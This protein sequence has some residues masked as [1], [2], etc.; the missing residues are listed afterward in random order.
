MDRTDYSI[1]LG[2]KNRELALPVVKSLHPLKTY[3][4]E[5]DGYPS[6]SKLVNDCI[7]AC[8][9][10]IIIFC[11]HKVRPT[12]Q[13]IERLLKLIDDGHGLATLYRFG[14]F[15]FKKELIRR[16]G[17]MDERYLIGGW[18]DDDFMIRLKEANISF[19][20]DESIEYI[21]GDSTWQHPKDKPFVSQ[22]HFKTKW[23]RDGKLHKMK[24]MMEEPTMPDKSGLGEAQPNV[25]FK[26]W[27]ESK[28]MSMSVW[29]NDF[30]IVRPEGCIEKKRILIFGGTGS[31]GNKLVE[32]YGSLNEIHVFSRDENKHWNMGMV[33]KDV[34]FIIGDIRNGDRVLEVV[35][36]VSADI[37]IVASAMKHVDRCE[38]EVSEAFETNCLGL[39]NV[40]KA[41]RKTQCVESVVFVSTDKACSPINTYGLT[42]GLGEKVMVAAAYKSLQKPEG[43]T[44]GKSPK[45]VTVRYGNV[46]NSRGSIIEVLNN[47]GQSIVPAYKL[48]HPDMTRF[49]MTQEHAVRLIDYALLHGESGDIIIPKLL[50]MKI[51]DLVEL[52][53]DKYKKSIVETGLRPGEKMHEALLNETELCR[54][55]QKDKYFVIKPPFNCSY[56]QYL[57]NI[58]Y[59]S[60][61]RAPNSMATKEQLEEALQILQLI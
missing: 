60:S 51:K 1:I 2:V 28:I 47:V 38:Y 12:P 49:L 59:D 53:A 22:Q 27:S 58:R 55:I 35:E 56:T 57:P 32:M 37:V 43:T 5:G 15:G 8:P 39:M 30:D 13:D 25:Q 36:S 10:E 18:E 33:H 20:Q 3:I 48:T 31:L 7:C 42:K 46:L 23:D 54:A 45:F 41:V 50:S 24:R 21:A 17:F 16:V 52:Y 6:F 29:I 14:C 19:Y 61:G 44:R 40:I 9:T 11:S 34:K 26:Q 4:V